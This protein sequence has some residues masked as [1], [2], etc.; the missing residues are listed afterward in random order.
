MPVNIGQSEDNSFGQPIGLLTDCHRRIEK[1]LG[2]LLAVAATRRGTELDDRDRDAMEKSL[3]YFRN[4]APWHTADEEHSLFPR[5]RETDDPNVQRLLNKVDA[6]E[7]DHRAAE[8]GHQQVD[9]LVQRWLDKHTLPEDAVNQ[10]IDVLTQL[11]ASYQR[12]IAIEDNEVFPLASQALSPVQLQAMGREMADRRGVD[13]NLP[14][15]R[16][17]HGRGARLA[18]QRNA[19]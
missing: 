1:F 13:P 15:R 3:R 4:A 11:Q 10:L 16:C 6:L 19:T 2:A 18:E 12:H 17:K 7:A 14:P 8:K 9:A 5:L